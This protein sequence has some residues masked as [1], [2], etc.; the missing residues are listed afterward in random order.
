MKANKRI[1]LTERDALAFFANHLD[2]LKWKYHYTDDKTTLFS[3]FNSEDVQWDFSAFARQKDS[4]LF[5]LGVNSFIPN[6]ALPE[7]RAAC[8]ELLTRLNFSLSIGCFEMNF[9]DG[10]IR[11][12]TAA[13]VP[14]TDITSGIIE[15]L[16][17]SN[18]SI[19]DQ[20]LK[21]IMA[22]L[23]SSVTPEEA[24]KPKE[25]NRETSPEPRFELN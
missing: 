16:L 2:E 10:E 18:L 9:K 5:L 1:E 25:E 3:G 17:R 21:A 23:Y 22:V 24:M 19:V 15:H 12:R 7:R 20:H 6:K 4:G 11:F 14:A 8:S 13:I